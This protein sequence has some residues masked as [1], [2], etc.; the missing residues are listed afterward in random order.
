MCQDYYYFYKIINW[1]YKRDIVKVEKR[2]F[3]VLCISDAVM[4]VRPEACE[5]I[6]HLLCCSGCTSALESRCLSPA[7]DREAPHFWSSVPHSARSP[8]P[9]ATPS[10]APDVSLCTA[11][12][13]L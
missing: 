1:I 4:A 3:L 12:T 8:A 10:P 11:D 9:G 6:P 5:I 2:L 7:T 13:Q